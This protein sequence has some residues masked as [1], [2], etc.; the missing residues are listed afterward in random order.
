M[1]TRWPGETRR[2]ARLVLVCLS[3]V[4]MAFL[5]GCDDDD[6][7]DDPFCVVGNTGVLRVEN[8]S[9]SSTYEIIID[10]SQT[11]ELGAGDSC[12]R[13]LT[14]GNHAL[15]FQCANSS[16]SACN[17]STPDVVQCSTRTISCSGGC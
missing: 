6:D 12:D 13:T 15:R 3:M 1:R 11:C 5:A 14:S 10:G 16:T 17:D 9:L 2:I 4:S 7:D 8:K